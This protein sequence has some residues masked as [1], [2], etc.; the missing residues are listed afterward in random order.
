MA[1]PR[2]EHTAKVWIMPHFSLNNANRASTAKAKAR[3]ATHVCEQ[4]GCW[5]QLGTGHKLEPMRLRDGDGQ[6][7]TGCGREPC[8]TLRAA[9]QF[10]WASKA[11]SAAMR[12]GLKVAQPKLGV[13]VSSSSV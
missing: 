3:S 9:G 8:F 5:H 6:V 7:C 4:E 13:D 10:G 1:A 2:A 11:D 12:Y